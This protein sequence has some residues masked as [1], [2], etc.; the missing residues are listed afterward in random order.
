MEIR[1]D[2]LVKVEDLH[3]M[4]TEIS[5]LCAFTLIKGITKMRQKIAPILYT[6]HIS[7]ICLFRKLFYSN[8]SWISYIIIA[9]D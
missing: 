1:E 8:H 4:L 9:G 3:S 6:D 5:Q 2:D 7:F